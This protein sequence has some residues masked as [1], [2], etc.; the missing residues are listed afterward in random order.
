MLLSKLPHY[1]PATPA[2]QRLSYAYETI[3]KPGSRRLYDLGGGRRYDPGESH[4][5]IRRGM[6]ADDGTRSH[7]E[8]RDGGGNG[9][10]HAPWSVEECLYGG[11]SLE[12]HSW[13][14]C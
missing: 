4:L 13:Y 14:L 7:G 2:F 3:S 12:S 1:A 11:E 10:R 9:R 8:G 5:Q 6:S